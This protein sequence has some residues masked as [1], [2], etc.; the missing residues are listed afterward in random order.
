MSDYKIS[1]INFE[2]N[3]NHIEYSNESYQFINGNNELVVN[4][5]D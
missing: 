2:V 5:C 1:R 4:C 3:S